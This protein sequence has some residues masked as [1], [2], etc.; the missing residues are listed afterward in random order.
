MDQDGDIIR[1]DVK[2]VFYVMFQ[3]VARKNYVLKKYFITRG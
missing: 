1:A 3:F 2:V